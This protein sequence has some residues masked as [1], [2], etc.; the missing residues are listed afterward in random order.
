MVSVL[1]RAKSLI[2]NS[3]HPFGFDIVPLRE[4]YVEPPPAAPKLPPLEQ[5]DLALYR[6]FYPQD[7]IDHHRFY[8]IGS[9][10]YF[11]HPAWTR[12]DYEFEFYTNKGTFDLSWNLL[13]LTPLPVPDGVAEAVYSSHTLEHVTNAA[14]VNCLREAY[15]VLKPGGYLR[16]TSPDIELFYRAFRQGDRHFFYQKGHNEHGYPNKRYKYNMNDAS[17]QQAFVWNFAAGATQV[18][19]EAPNPLTDEEIQTYFDALPLEEALDACVSRCSLEVQARHPGNHINWFTKEKLIRMIK[20][21]GFET[22][23]ISGFGQS[24]CPVMRDTTLFDKRRPEFSL[25]I[26][27]V[28]A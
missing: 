1:K 26:E 25:Y 21:A 5:F 9:G 19:A 8:N 27:A 10:T 4:V 23:Y 18:H 7:S 17:I 15:R 11:Y 16:I 14:V 20:E 28:K 12:V 22:V 6:Q 13:A 24:Y 3:L 2:R